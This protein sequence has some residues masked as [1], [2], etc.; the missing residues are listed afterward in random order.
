MFLNVGRPQIDPDATGQLKAPDLTKAKSLIEASGTSGQPVVVWAF[1][2]YD[3]A[4]DAQ[5]TRLA[6]EESANP[7]VSA[8]L[9]GAL[10]REIADNAPWVPLFTPTYVDLTAARVG[11]YQAQGGQALLDQLW[12]R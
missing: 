7:A 6:N 9:A 5:L 2:D 1:A 4:V 3:H 10:D 12:V 8:Q 11:N